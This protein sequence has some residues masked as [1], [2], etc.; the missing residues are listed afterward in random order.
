VP[1][2][3]SV[4]ETVERLKASV[5]NAG[6]R[7]FG[8]VDFGGGIRSIGEDIGDI[9][10]VIFGDPRI[11][12]QAPAADSMAALDLPGKVLVYGT[13]EGSAMS[14]TGARNLGGILC[15][16][17]SFLTSLSSTFLRLLRTDLTADL[18]SA[19]LAPVSPAAYFTS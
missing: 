17:A 19:L 10:L 8:V 11:G 14:T 3:G 12:V 9:Q 6:A 1:S 16:G 7:V 5:E 2:A 15:R 13:P 4:P 18:T